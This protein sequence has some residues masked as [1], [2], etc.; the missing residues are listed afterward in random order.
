MQQVANQVLEWQ[1]HAVSNDN[2][3]ER[4][5][6]PSGVEEL[7][8][9][10]IEVDFTDTEVAELEEAASDFG[11]TFDE[12]LRRLVLGYRMPDTLLDTQKDLF[13]LAGN[14]HITAQE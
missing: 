12:Y 10:E 8:P 13:E 9:C 6:L 3:L 11:L 1:K 14:E 5:T 4:P 2:Y 7:L